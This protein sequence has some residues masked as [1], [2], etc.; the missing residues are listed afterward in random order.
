MIEIFY[1]FYNHV[2][3][4]FTVWVRSS[5]KTE[6]TRRVASSIPAEDKRVIHEYI[7]RPW[8]SFW[9]WLEQATQGF[10]RTLIAFNMHMTDSLVRV[11]FFFMKNKMFCTL[12]SVQSQEIIVIVNLREF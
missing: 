1:S 10:A 6:C 12:Y 2:K 4:D 8:V 11:S 7:S 5:T 3:W 9:I